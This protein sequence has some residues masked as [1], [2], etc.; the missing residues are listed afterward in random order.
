M[1]VTLYQGD[2]LD[3]LARIPSGSVDCVVSDPPY[4]EIDRPYGRL[5][6]AEWHTLMRAV[7]AETRRILT[8]TGSAMFVVQPNSAR[9]GSMRLW[10]WDFLAW[11]GREWN[12]VQDAYWW[13][14]TAL[15]TKHSNRAVG[16]LR[17][18][19]KYCIWLGAA[20]CYRS[21][22]DVLWEESARSVALRLGGRL[23]NNPRYTPRHGIMRDERA[24]AAAIE[25]G[26]VTPFNV[27]PISS[28]DSTTS[29]GALGHGAGTP[30]ELCDWWLRYLCPPGGTAA[31]PFMGSGTTGEAAIKRGL[32][33]IGIER[34][35][36]YF[37][38][39]QARIVAAQA[40][41]RQLPLEA[42]S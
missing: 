16:L 28:G 15:P 34:D 25:R 18:S 27:L 32:G 36:G 41:A 19:L 37:A 31:D 23:T 10:V 5:T 4:A 33:F 11:V 20:D 17:P 12:I 22:G 40:R 30:A 13:N 9:V 39:A 21:Q 26:G 24:H 42:A 1:S 6:E 38:T 29:A 7:V 14:Y 3:E 35:P 2:C 8:P